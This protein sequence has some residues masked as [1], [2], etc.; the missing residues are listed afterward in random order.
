MTMS[1]WQ[2]SLL[3]TGESLQTTGESL[4]TQVSHNDSPVMSNEALL[5][6]REYTQVNIVN[7]I[8]PKIH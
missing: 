6:T 5:I 3:I 2:H 8:K 7:S 1:H 4:L